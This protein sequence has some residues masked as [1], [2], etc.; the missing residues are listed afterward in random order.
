MACA[1]NRYQVHSYAH[2]EGSRNMRTPLSFV[3]AVLITVTFLAGPAGAE[4]KE[5][6]HAKV[7]YE[8]ISS[9]YAAALAETL[10]AAR[11]VYVGTLKFDMPDSVMLEVKCGPTEATRLYT[12]G[13][14]R[15]FLSLSSEDQLAQPTKSGVFNLYGMCHELGH[16]AMYRTLKNRD[17]MT[18]AAAEGWAHYAGSVVVDRVWT[19]KGE[20]LWPDRY[21]YRADGTAR[22]NKQLA[23]TKTSPIGQGAGQWQ[24]LEAII[25]LPQFS[26]LFAAWEAAEVDAT[27]P[28]AGLLAVLEKMQPAK[29]EAI[30]EWWKVAGPLFVDH[31]AAS[32]TKAETVPVGQLSGKPT[33]LKYDDDASDGK[34]SI[35]GGGHAVAFRAPAG[36]KWYLRA[37]SVYGARYG[38]P[39]APPSP[40]D[41]ALCDKDLA[42]IATWRR[43]I[44]T[45]GYGGMG[46]TRLEVPPTR[47]PAGFQVCLD[48]KPTAT[49]GVYVGFDSSTHGHSQVA[50]PGKKGGPLG[51][52]DW[53]I[54]VELDQAKDADPLK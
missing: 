46:W 7:S 8:G 40:F 27:K 15:L 37:I 6:P 52:G 22:L 10:A 26:K 41:I 47:V 17:W 25:G 18:S 19:A 43:P 35:A 44:G 32:K 38:T 13:E 30:A 45:F 11:Q 29:K 28:D 53:M 14:D 36:G 48:F 16:M 39:K 24:K 49:K 51:E 33:V 2:G 42:V 5:I 20:K 1:S 12:D 34:K 21:D 9:E 54:R 23:A 4:V 3:V 50:T 31:V